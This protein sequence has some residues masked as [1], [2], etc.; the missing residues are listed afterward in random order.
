MRFKEFICESPEEF[1][2]Y[3]D[4]KPAVKYSSESDALKDINLIKKK[5]PNVVLDL[6]KEVCQVV[7]IKHVSEGSVFGQQDFDTQ[8]NLAKLKNQLTQPRA[9]QSAPEPEQTLEPAV[10]KPQR[11]SD[12]QAKHEKLLPIVQA[13]KELEQLKDKLTRGGRALPP[14]LAADIEDYYTMSDVEQYPQEVLQKYIK[15]LAA[16]KKYAS[17]KKAVWK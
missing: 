4:N 12:L 8:L 3:V 6:K 10:E 16:L 2:L 14:G 15:Q 13:K 7:N 11:L 9:A 5:M 1:V 17:L